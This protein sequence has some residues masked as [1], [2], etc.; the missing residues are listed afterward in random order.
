MQLKFQET[1]NFTLMTSLTS[2]TRALEG[3]S[4]SSSLS[5]YTTSGFEFLTV[6]ISI[7]I[8][9]LIYRKKKQI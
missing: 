6:P 1:I 2:E 5:T 3:N 8:T 7:L 4:T 9:G